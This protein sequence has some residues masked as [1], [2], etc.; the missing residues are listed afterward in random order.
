MLFPNH[1]LQVDVQSAKEKAKQ[2]SPVF[3]E[4]FHVNSLQRGHSKAS[5]R[6]P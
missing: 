2:R 4:P 6:L 1:Q 5:F 3:S